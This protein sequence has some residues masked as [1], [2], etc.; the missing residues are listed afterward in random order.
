[1]IELKKVLPPIL[2]PWLAAAGVWVAYQR[3]VAELALGQWG[4]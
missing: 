1:M 3:L 2:I 4:M